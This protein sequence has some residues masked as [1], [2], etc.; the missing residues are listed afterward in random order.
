MKIKLSLGNKF[1]IPTLSLIILSVSLVA[2]TSYVFSR[3]MLSGM[4]EDQ[5]KQMAD[6]T[7]TRV[8]AYLKDRKADATSW[9]RLKLFQAAVLDSFIGKSS[10]GPAG[11]EL[12]KIKE[13][14]KYF[15]TIG[16][17]NQ[18]GEVVASSDGNQTSN[19]SIAD[20]EYFKRS[21]KGD[22]YVSEV[23]V[24]KSTGG[25]I[26]V[27]S[28]PVK[29][30]DQVTGVLFC[31]VDLGVF[32]SL[33]IDPLKVGRNGYAYVFQKDGLILAHPDKSI[34]MK[35][36]SNDLTPG[37]GV[38]SN[39]GGLVNF[40]ERGESRTAFLQRNEALDWTL[41]IVAD[42]G[43]LLAP[44]KHLAAICLGIAALAALLAVG[45][46]LGI[47]R[48]IVKSID[49]IAGKLT[50]G[51]DEVAS[52]SRRASLTSEELSESASY[53]ASALEESASSLEEMASMT[54][55][56]ADNA[57]QAEKLVEESMKDF[58]EA[59]GAVTGL[60]AAMREISQA[61]TDTQKIVKTIDEIAFQTNLL[62]L[63][64][65]V[66]AARAGEAGAGFAVV[67]DE[68]RNLAVRAADAARNTA[69]L[70]EGTVSRVQGGTSYVDRASSAFA[71][72][73]NVS[74]NIGRLVSQISSACEEQAQG[75]QQ[76]SKAV[77]GIDDLTQ[78]NAAGAQE[79]ASISVQMS[80]RAGQMNGVVRELMILVGGK[81]SAEN[82]NG[83]GDLPSPEPR[84]TPS[85]KG[86][87][88]VSV[89]SGER[90]AFPE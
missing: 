59:E 23:V 75:I 74:E 24:S 72:V 57:G 36:R 14:Y 39:A 32:S 28:A 49:R 53:Q 85:V 19:I 10:R 55:Q 26:F 61:S 63:N 21:L 90:R 54:R 16:V 79:S 4:V 31:A 29:E 8:S 84:D 48:S 62:A 6:L 17:A 30:K 64:A 81:R 77:S 33:F 13:D 38:A 27:I 66:E 68:V 87:R 71:K 73:K 51:A 22:V 86:L 20:R 89:H 80:G 69:Q 56:N 34:I 42:N 5:V 35:A 88:V 40:S 11:E 83:D 18:A 50:E 43:E 76:V 41:A 67:A 1:L 25:N 9:S 70:I 2:V 60:A 37:L 58:G 15:A 46:I 7:N 78:R 12:G 52:F 44:L 65:A 45:L 47:V 3:R 82:R